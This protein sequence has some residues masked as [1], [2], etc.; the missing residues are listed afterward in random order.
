M[1]NQRQTFF[2]FNLTRKFFC[3]T[4]R[5]LEALDFEL[6]NALLGSKEREI[7]LL[8]LGVTTINDFLFLQ[9]IK[10]KRN[11]TLNK[12]WCMSEQEREQ[13]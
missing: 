9:T 8:P 10:Y 12:L 11:Y 1:I 4:L 3:A 5:N 13:K 7:T 2:T 6:W